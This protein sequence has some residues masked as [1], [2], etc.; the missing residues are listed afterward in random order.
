MRR[1]D[2][3]EDQSFSPEEIFYRRCNPDF[4]FEEAGT[5]R[6]LADAFRDHNLSTARS[7]YAEPDHARWDSVSDPNNPPGF[8]ARL[9]RD[10]YVIGIRLSDLPPPVTPDGGKLHEMRAVHVPFDD[11]YAHTELRVF[12]DGHWIEKENKFKSTLTRE[13]FRTWLADR[14]TVFLKPNQV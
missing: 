4:A 10:W 14:A 12:K 13:K 2:R 8:I 3:T 11:H 5:L 6:I 7:K 1:N 9:W